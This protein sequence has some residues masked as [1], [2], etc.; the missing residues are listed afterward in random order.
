MFGFVL[1]VDFFRDNPHV[2]ES[3][4]FELMSRRSRQKAQTCFH[5][6]LLTTVAIPVVYE[7]KVV[8]M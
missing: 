5:S 7:P 1:C 3:E 6:P 8:L 2:V 4:V